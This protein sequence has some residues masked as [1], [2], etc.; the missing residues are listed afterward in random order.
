MV[1]NDIVIMGD[2][3]M[4]EE[5]LQEICINGIVEEEEDGKEDKDNENEI[6]LIP[7]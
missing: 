2:E 7:T 4:K 1:D 5:I 6:V 3:M